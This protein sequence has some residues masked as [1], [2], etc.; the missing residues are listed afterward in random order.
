MTTELTQDERDRMI[1][2]DPSLDPE[3]QRQ[4]T[5][6]QYDGFGA[7]DLDRREQADFEFASGLVD[8]YL[9][10]QQWHTLPGGESVLDLATAIGAVMTEDE[11]AMW[12]NDRNDPGDR[13]AAAQNCLADMIFGKRFYKRNLGSATL[14]L[15]GRLHDLYSP[16]YMRGGQPHYVPQIYFIEVS[17]D[18]LLARAGFRRERADGSHTAAFATTFTAADHYIGRNGKPQL[19]FYRTDNGDPNW[20]LPGQT[21]HS[22]EAA[23]QARDALRDALHTVRRDRRTAHVPNTPHDERPSPTIGA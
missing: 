4:L 8:A 6:R 7:S 17:P 21:F 13:L 12:L 14:D 18:G 19:S 11:V 23:I 15:D 1:A 9:V 3:A 2:L 5:V 20:S 22:I 16:V 10:T